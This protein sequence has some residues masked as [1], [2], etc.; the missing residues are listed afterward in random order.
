MFEPVRI[1]LVATLLGTTLGAMG[2]PAHGQWTNDADTLSTT[3]R[4]GIGT[5]TP[6][7]RLDLR[8]SQFLQD[9]LMMGARGLSASIKPSSGGSRG[10]PGSDWAMLVPMHTG[11][12][13]SDL[14]L[15]VEDD[16][17]DRF[18]SPARRADSHYG[19]GGSKASAP[20]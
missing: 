16:A 18:A 17:A 7:V 4:A 8:G 20:R 5:S 11:T 15:Y 9:R 1:A 6:A 10:W 14:R 13:S 2:T 3:D 12:Q 19:V